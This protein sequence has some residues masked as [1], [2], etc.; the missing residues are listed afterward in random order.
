MPSVLL[1]PGRTKSIQRRHPW[2][3]SGAIG[4]VVGDP[5]PGAT[6][7]VCA[8]DGTRLAAGA[9]SPRSQ[10]AVRVWS[11]EPDQTI[12]RNWFGERLDRALDARASN[13]FRSMV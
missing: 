11:F 13:Q 6:V 3:F 7:D 1:K 5:Q 12:D 2:I 4:S 10:I 9:Y 8:P